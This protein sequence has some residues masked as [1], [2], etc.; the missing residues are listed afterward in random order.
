MANRMIR[1]G[2]FDGIFESVKKQALLVCLP[3]LVCCSR[4]GE[5][6]LPVEPLQPRSEYDL[7]A[8]E[9]RIMTQS[10]GPHQRRI[11]VGANVWIFTSICNVGLQSIKD[12]DFSQSLELNGKIVV[13]PV[14]V[15]NSRQPPLR[16]GGCLKSVLTS[17]RVVSL[18]GWGFRPGLPGRYEFKL[19]AHLEP[20]LE[21]ENVDNNEL[22][23]VIEVEQ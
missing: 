23:V 12:A 5:N 3:L 7:E 10:W 1:G 19:R 15:R 20:S 18:G 14:F 4:A 6:P 13:Q 9:L 16:P 8:R 21:E 2:G 11:K 17:P 22:V